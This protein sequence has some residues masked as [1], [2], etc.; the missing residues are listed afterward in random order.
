MI[1]SSHDKEV[2]FYYD[3][4]YLLLIL[5]HTRPPICHLSERGLSSS[6]DITVSVIP[7]QIYTQ[8]DNLYSQ[9]YNINPG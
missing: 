2:C 1:D 4:S 3:I 6:V 8:S 9:C 5:K 7:H